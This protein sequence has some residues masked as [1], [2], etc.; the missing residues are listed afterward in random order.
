M[1]CKFAII[2]ALVLLTL[3]F[4]VLVTLGEKD[5]KTRKFFGYILV[6]LLWISTVF[7]LIGSFYGMKYH[8]PMMP[9]S[10][11]HHPTMQK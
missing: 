9:N 4:L 8:C 5:H 7:V 2:I 11:N 3:S 1:C 10:E 6:I